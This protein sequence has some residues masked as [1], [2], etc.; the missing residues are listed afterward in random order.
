M[1]KTI[2]TLRCP[3]CA[4]EDVRAIFYTVSQGTQSH[5]EW[6]VACQNCG[7]CGPNDL[8]KSGA[9]EMWNMRREFPIKHKSMIRPNKF[10]D[11]MALQQWTLELHNN[12]FEE[13]ELG[14][15]DE[16]D[17]SFWEWLDRH[18]PSIMSEFK[19]SF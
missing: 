11:S 9:I 3:F 6:Q 17:F 2:Q 14:L 7:A 10:L 4:S 15:G 8:G 18:Y 1:S 19:K 5:K 12:V 16:D 13:W